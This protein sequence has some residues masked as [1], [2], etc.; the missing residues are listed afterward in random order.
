[1]VSTVKNSHNF[2]IGLIEWNLVNEQGQFSDKPEY[3]YVAD[4][5]I[6]EGQRWSDVFRELIRIVDDHPFSK[7]ARFVY[8]DFLR[9]KQG[10]RIFD[11]SGEDF[12]GLKQ[13]RIYGREYIADKILK[14]GAAKC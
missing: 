1:M 10:K 8:W 6:H 13:S 4:I 7:D 14:R 12:K 2:V 5:W 9:D 3:L 11:N